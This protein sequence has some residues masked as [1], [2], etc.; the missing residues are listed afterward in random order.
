MATKYVLK[1]VCPR[2][3][4]VT[5]EKEVTELAWKNEMYCADD[6][7]ALKGVVE[8]G[9]NNVA[10]IWKELPCTACVEKEY[11]SSSMYY[12]LDGVNKVEVDRRTFIRSDRSGEYQTVHTAAGVFVG[13]LWSDLD[14]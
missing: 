12:E 13:V 1:Y 11:P 2:C 3:G 9:N 4:A 14:D 7:S 6:D 8:E 5:S 10:L